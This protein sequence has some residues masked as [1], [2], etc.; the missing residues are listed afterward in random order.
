MGNFGKKQRIS[1]LSRSEFIC[2]QEKN[3]QIELALKINS[4]DHNDHPILVAWSSASKFVPNTKK[5]FEFPPLLLDLFSENR[6][7]HE[8]PLKCLFIL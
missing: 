8:I 3:Q 4:V 1:S 7:I 6:V 2:N 5:T